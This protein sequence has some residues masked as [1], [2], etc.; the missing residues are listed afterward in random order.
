MMAQIT[1]IVPVYNVEPYLERCLN[2]I[3]TQNYRDYDVVLIDDGSSDG[4]SVLCD[5]YAELYPYIHTIHQENRGLSAARNV[6]IEWAL[7]DSDSRYLTFIDSDDW[8]HPQYLE[9][10]YKTMQVNECGVAVGQFLQTCE[11]A[12]PFSFISHKAKIF[13]P[14]ELYYQSVASFIVAWGKLY[15]KGDFIKLRFPEG[16]IHEDEFTIWKVMLKYNRVAVIDTPIYA[17]FQRK[18]SIMNSVWSMERMVLFDALEEQREWIDQNGDERLQRFI[19]WRLAIDSAT[20]IRKMREINVDARILKFYKNRLKSYI[21][22]ARLSLPFEKY[23]MVYRTA[24]PL[25]SKVWIRVLRLHRKIHHMCR[26]GKE[27]L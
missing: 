13:T 18:D 8:I 15:N 1:V 10:L 14:S 2:S 26:K 11:K 5:Q 19:R 17:Y 23:Y 3:V 7:T 6:G 20:L 9:L 27:A 16:K 25:T 24:W 4:S 12:I 21:W 22:D